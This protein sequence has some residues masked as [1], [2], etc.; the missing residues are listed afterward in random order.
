MIAVSC[1]T[2]VSVRSERSSS[3]EI[4]LCK[5]CNPLLRRGSSFAGRPRRTQTTP[6]API[7]TRF[8]RICKRTQKLTASPWK[9]YR[10]FFSV[11]GGDAGSQERVFGVEFQERKL[12]L[13]RWR[14]FIH[15]RRPCGS[16]YLNFETISRMRSH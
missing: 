1:E 5:S 11:E 14:M 9:T 10:D 6:T 2:W 7:K 13:G 15:P 8:S 16:G 3:T 4:L 12:D